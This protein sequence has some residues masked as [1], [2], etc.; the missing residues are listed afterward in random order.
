MRPKAAWWSLSPVHPSRDRAAIGIA[1][2][3]GGPGV[4]ADIL[5]ALRAEDLPPVLVVQHIVS[6]FAEGFARWLGEVCGRPTIIA[7]QGV[8]ASRGTIYVA[9]DDHHLELEPGGKL[10]VRSTPAVGM[11]RPS[12]T[13]L[14]ESLGRVLGHRAL[15][16]VLTGMGA[17]GAEGARALRAAGGRLVIQDEASSVVFGMPR[18]ARD[19][20]GA[21][22]TLSPRRMPAWIRDWLAGRDPER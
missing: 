20:A 11:F 17:D 5:G 18:A 15:G 3:T 21:D 13:P 7:E 6:G 22:A 9:P 8:M 19:L 2:S 14:F 16:I 4:L 1:A 10:A 12:A